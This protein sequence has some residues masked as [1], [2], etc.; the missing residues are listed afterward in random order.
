M[1][2]N[3]Q[4][5]AEKTPKEYANIQIWSLKTNLLNAICDWGAWACLCRESPRSASY[6]VGWAGGYGGSGEGG[7]EN[8]GGYRLQLTLPPTAAWL[9]VSPAI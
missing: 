5:G 3:K 9:Q 2:P 8:A 1:F 6:K 4:K 7:R